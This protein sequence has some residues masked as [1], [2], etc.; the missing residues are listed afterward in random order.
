MQLF[1]T[2]L[3]IKK[4][5]NICKGVY[6]KVFFFFFIDVSFVEL[7]FNLSFVQVTI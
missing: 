7:P 1:K 3:E 6:L 2:L 4:N 5:A